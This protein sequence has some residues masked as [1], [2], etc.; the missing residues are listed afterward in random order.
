VVISLLISAPVLWFLHALNL[1]T[2]LCI[3]GLT[4]FFIYFAVVRGLGNAWKMGLTYLL[5]NAVQIAA[6]LVVFGLFGLHTGT[7]ALAIYSLTYFAP[8]VMELIRP[9]P[10]PRH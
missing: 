5:S 6:L 10:L 1:G 2:I 8:I 3:V 7:I 4:G 9:M